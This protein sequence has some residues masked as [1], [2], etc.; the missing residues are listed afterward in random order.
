MEQYEVVTDPLTPLEAAD[1]LL[2][3]R[4][5]IYNISELHGLKATLAP[6]LFPQAG[7]SRSNI[8]AFCL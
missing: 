8:F 5:V 2:I 4:E 7:K 3:T 1:A 6:K